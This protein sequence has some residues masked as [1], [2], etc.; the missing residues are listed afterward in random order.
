MVCLGEAL[1]GTANQLDWCTN[2]I[3][4]GVLDGMKAAGLK[5]EPP[6]VIRTHA[7]D[8]D[9]IM[10]AAYQMYSKFSPRSKYNGESL[11]TWEPRGKEAAIH[12]AM[13]KLGPHLVN[14]H[15]LSNLEPFRYGDKE[16]IQK[17]V[18]ASRDRLGATGLHLYPLSYW[19]WPYSPD[20]ADPPLL[21]MGARLDL[22]RGLGALFV[23]SGHSGKGGPRLLDFAA[24]GI[25]RQHQRGGENSG[26]LQQFRRSRAAT[27][28][29]VRHHRRQPP[30]AVAGHDARPTGGSR[31]NTRRIADLW[32]SQAPP[33]ERLDEYVKKE[34][35][36]EPHVG[37]TPESIIREVLD[38]S[39]Q[40]GR[41]RRC[42]RAAGDKKSRRVRAAAQ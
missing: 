14:I 29:A 1:R 7:M 11:T 39:Q 37:E 12:L 15:I 35:N 40:S 4:P 21:A 20:I 26:G 42:R 17:C 5:E 2:V 18:Q 6:V 8:A 25:L 34:W 13:S 19:N 30:D 22:V 38:Y 32:V 3:L 36:H 16:F 23:E 41:R 24:G 10:P 33:G 9:A 27:D 28:P 31:R